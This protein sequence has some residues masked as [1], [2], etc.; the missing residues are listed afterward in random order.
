M[1]G[2]SCTLPTAWNCLGDMFGWC[3]PTFNEKLQT[4]TTSHGA[5]DNHNNILKSKFMT[6]GK[7]AITYIGM[8]M[9]FC[10][11]KPYH[12]PTGT[13]LISPMGISFT[14]NAREEHSDCQLKILGAICPE[15]LLR[16]SA[17]SN[18]SNPYFQHEMVQ[19]LSG[20]LYPEIG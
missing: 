15:Y 2:F 14:V 1:G 4:T 17:T 13:T 16:E 9:F 3:L 6:K 20:F 8:T 10:Q 19:T 7:A 5:L 12:L 18:S 11:D